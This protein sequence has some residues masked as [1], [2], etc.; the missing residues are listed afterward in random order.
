MGRSELINLEVQL[1]DGTFLDYGIGPSAAAATESTNTG[2][3]GVEEVGDTALLAK[4]WQSDRQPLDIPLKKMLHIHA[5]LDRMD[6][7]LDGATHK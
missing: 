6:H 1:S 4:R 2:R 7:V 5:V 3:L